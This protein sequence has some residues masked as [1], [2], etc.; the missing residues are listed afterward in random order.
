MRAILKILLVI[1]LLGGL[2]CS[3]ASSEGIYTT[4]YSPTIENEPS[5]IANASDILP[6]GNTPVEIAVTNDS[7]DHG[8]VQWSPDGEWLVYC[9][10][11]KI[12]KVSANGSTTTELI[13]ES[14]WR[15]ENI[16]W[17]PDG[18]WI[19]YSMDLG[20][21]QQG[22]HIYKIRSDGSERV[23]LTTGNYIA[24]RGIE[25][26]P[27]GNWLASIR[28]YWE[29]SKDYVVKINPN[30]GAQSI[31]ASCIYPSCGFTGGTLDWS[32]DGSWIIYG[33]AI[34]QY[35]GY[36]LFIYKVRSTG[37]SESFVT[38]PEDDYEQN[39]HFN[40]KFSPDDSWVAFISD[41]V[42]SMHNLPKKIRPDG[43]EESFVN[44]SFPGSYGLHWSPDGNWLLYMTGDESGISQIFKIKPDGT[45]ATFLT[46][47]DYSRESPN[48]SPDGQWVAYS[49]K[50]HTGYWQIYKITVSTGQTDLELV[51]MYLTNISQAWGPNY[52]VEYPKTND[53]YLGAIVKNNGPSNISGTNVGFYVN[54]QLIGYGTLGSLTVGETK[55]IDIKWVLQNNVTEG[56]RVRVTVDPEQKIDTDMSNNTKE[57]TVSIYYALTP[58]ENPPEGQP[59]DLRE[60]VYGQFSNTEADLKWEG[61]EEYEHYQKILEN[62]TC[63]NF[64]Q[65]RKLD[66]ITK[67]YWWWTDKDGLCFGFAGTTALYFKN[68]LSKPDPNEQVFNLTKDEAA[69]KIKQYQH[70]QQLMLPFSSWFEG[71]KKDYSILVKDIKEGRP[72]FIYLTKFSLIDFTLKSNLHAVLAYKVLDMGDRAVIYVYENRFKYGPGYTTKIRPFCA[73]FDFRDGRNDFYYEEQFPGIVTENLDYNY[74]ANHQDEFNLWGFPYQTKEPYFRHCN[75]VPLFPLACD[76]LGIQINTTYEHLLSIL[77]SI[78]DKLGIFWG[79]IKGWAQDRLGRR[80]GFVPSGNSGVLG[81]PR[82]TFEFVNEIDGATVDTVDGAMIFVLPDS[83]DYEFNLFATSADTVSLNFLDPLVADSS[84]F[85]HVQFDS[86]ILSDSSTASFNFSADVTSLSLLADIDGDGDLDTAIVPTFE[87]GFR[88]GDANNDSRVSVSDVVYL[89]NYLFKGGPP[90]TPLIAANV[91]CDTSVSVSDVVY[92]INYL[93][94]GGT[95]PRSC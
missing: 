41:G 7:Y 12:Y 11:T 71:P 73:L 27:D 44:Q 79:R 84:T 60:D 2:F 38:P 22:T 87:A 66:P 30:T 15:I 50:D 48:W 43:T 3:H 61:H 14:G 62:E 52:T 65:K 68:P 54:D 28:S 4:S 33:K 20:T 67:F 26:S 74:F 76:D 80:A 81:K 25:W 45:L 40:G 64:G 24:Y 93:F 89:V 72:A 46:S 92:L 94:K 63:F 75:I 29:E 16:R 70:Y 13:N 31:L 49:K 5:D 58:P 9:N 36:L 91:N 77:R 78:G 42:S 51:D 90:P 32:H 8:N 23:R 35:I 85:V 56:A 19:A 53:E 59:F 95:P 82:D 21:T 57:K 1:G 83:L 39:D 10:G 55:L 47:G 86:V 18:N 6:D 69:P 34:H 17:S 37:G 88:R